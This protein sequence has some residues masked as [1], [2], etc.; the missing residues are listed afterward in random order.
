MDNILVFLG[1]LGAILGPVGG[2]V[3][4]VMLDR[5]SKR[6]NKETTFVAA[7]EAATHEFEAITAGYTE[8]T[9]KLET[10]A[11]RADSLEKRVDQLEKIL[12]NLIVYVEA[13]EPHVAPENRPVRPDLS[14]DR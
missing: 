7:K 2:V 4:A 11:N 3:T 5:R 10:R 13:L 14:F 6:N 9:T 8:Y 1:F 12:K